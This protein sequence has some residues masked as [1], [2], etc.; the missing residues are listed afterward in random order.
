MKIVLIRPPDV[1]L[2]KYKEMSQGQHP[3]NLLFLAGYIQPRHEPVIL[4]LQAVHMNKEQVSQY[5]K[6][7]N[8]DAVGISFM[9]CNFDS[10]KEIADMAKELGKLVIL[11]G[12][13][14]TIL[15]KQTLEEINA[16]IVI[17]NEGEITL[18]EVLDAAEDKKSLDG[19]KGIA[20]KK[21]GKIIDNAIRPFVEN[22]DD[23]PVPDRR[24]LD[25]KHSRGATT[26]GVAKDSTVMFTSRGCAFQCIF[27]S[28]R[29]IHGNRYRSRSMDHIFKEI[30]QIKE[31]GFEHISIEDDNFTF[32]NNRV[33]EFCER[34]KPYGITWDV[35]ARVGIPLD[36]L[37]K[38]K[39]AG[40]VKVAFGV[41]SGSPRVLDVIKKHINL[42]GITDTFRNC[43]KAGIKTLAFFMVGHP[44]ETKEDIGMTLNLIKKI[45]PDYLFVSLAT[46]YP[47]TPLYD[48]MMEKGFIEKFDW[49]KFSFFGQ[50]VEWRTE[51]FNK[52]E[53][54]KLRSDMY[55]KFYMSPGYIFKS[56]SE[57]RS[58]GDLKQLIQGAKVLFSFTKK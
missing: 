29:L 8:P 2:G 36:V 22:L 14:P 28:A 12:P 46:P 18:K 27:C 24:L 54:I 50:D 47:G 30:D 42:D 19:I 45:K 34:I 17:K 23:L 51:N 7:Q 6:N 37:K 44:T 1:G 53:L 43:R 21:D 41:E 35:Q 38:M 39:D 49:S 40:C 55:K 32:S 11:G 15:P 13:H 56:I 33:E 58:V 52:E 57:V 25:L 5:L 20:F 4:D 16:D 31:L 3:V 48:H 10:V 9:T 26:T